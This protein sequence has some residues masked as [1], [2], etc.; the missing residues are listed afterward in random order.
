MPS[1]ILIAVLLGFLALSGCSAL[2]VDSG[3]QYDVSVES[4]SVN[5]SEI[6]VVAITPPEGETLPKGAHVTVDGGYVEF[7]E[8]ATMPYDETVY[9]TYV[10]SRTKFDLTNELDED[11]RGLDTTNFT[12]SEVR[13]SAQGSTTTY[14]L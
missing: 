12:V 3:P 7:T 9:L 13:I 8:M 6:R 1:K 5:D 2:P 4:V 10:P 14:E 11:V